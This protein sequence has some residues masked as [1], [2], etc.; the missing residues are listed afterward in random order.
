M[1]TTDAHAAPEDHVPVSVVDA[2]RSQHLLANQQLHT[3]I[4]ELEHTN[5][6]LIEKNMALVDSMQSTAHRQLLHYE[7]TVR[8]LCVRV[9]M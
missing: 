2:L 3:R 8:R 7:G 6:H 1:L 5:N 9:L 4:A